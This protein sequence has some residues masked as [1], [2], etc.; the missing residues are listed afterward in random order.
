M[1]SLQYM[2]LKARDDFDYDFYDPYDY[3]DVPWWYSKFLVGRRV[4]H[5]P[6][7]TR[8][9]QDNPQPDSYYM[10]SMPPPPVYDP[11]RPPMYQPPKEDPRLTHRNG[12]QSS[13]RDK[14]TRRFQYQTTSPRQDLRLL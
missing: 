6:L 5:H 14:W 7:H 11:T 1:P 13:R 3:S 8:V 4:H 10:N 9:P 12:D 2:A